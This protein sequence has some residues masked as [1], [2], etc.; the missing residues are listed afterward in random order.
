M[1]EKL[2]L[3]YVKTYIQCAKLGGMGGHVSPCTN[4]RFPS[5]ER[6]IVVGW[7]PKRLLS[8]KYREKLNIFIHVACGYGL[9]RYFPAYLVAIMVSFVN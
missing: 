9:R 7:M 2:R 4:I 3:R 8:D 1:L 5:K 6:K